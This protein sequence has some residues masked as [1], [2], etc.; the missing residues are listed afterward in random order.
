[1]LTSN[2]VEALEH[3]MVFL[4]LLVVLVLSIGL[5][6]WKGREIW[7]FIMDTGVCCKL[8][9][10]DDDEA[11]PMFRQG[12]NRGS[13]RQSKRQTLNNPFVYQP[14]EDDKSLARHHAYFAG[15]IDR[16]S[17]NRRNTLPK[18]ESK[19]DSKPQPTQETPLDDSESS[20]VEQLDEREIDTPRKIRRLQKVKRNSLHLSQIFQIFEMTLTP[21]AV[22]Y[23]ESALRRRKIPTKTEVPSPDGEP[24][25]PGVVTSWLNW[26]AQAGLSM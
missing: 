9:D 18:P 26:T 24:K 21:G 5:A 20:N 16:R 23:C 19:P 13:L 3:L 6:A 10:D 4:I 15:S 12:S 22:K 2:Q 11:T 25:K 1:M 7:R 17:T 8:P 14:G